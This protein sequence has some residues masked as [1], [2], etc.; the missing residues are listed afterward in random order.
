MVQALLAPI[1]LRRTKDTLN[2]AGE[3]I[4]SLT[5]IEVSTVML[6]F[7]PAERDFYQV[8][9]RMLSLILSGCIFVCN[10]FAVGHLQAIA[11]QV[12]RLSGGW[13]GHEVPFLFLF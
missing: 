7:D 13:D 9:L 1:L 5:P 8:I 11:H 2:A 6:D 3:R 12:W 4:L 10:T